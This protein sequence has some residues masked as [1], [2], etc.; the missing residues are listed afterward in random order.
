MNGEEGV[1]GAIQST[2]RFLVERGLRNVFVDLMHEYN[3]ERADLEILKEP[4]GPAKKPRSS[5]KSRCSVGFQTN[6][7]VTALS[8]GCRHLRKTVTRLRRR[9]SGR[10]R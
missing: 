3:H 8:G 1:K 9:I 2:G 4:D 10:A 5:T 7:L 6:G